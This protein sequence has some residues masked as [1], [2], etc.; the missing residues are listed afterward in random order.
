[1]WVLNYV[2]VELQLRL[3]NQAGVQVR[4]FQSTFCNKLLRKFVSETKISVTGSISSVF[5]C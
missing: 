3:Q 4:F 1:M 5:K 2:G